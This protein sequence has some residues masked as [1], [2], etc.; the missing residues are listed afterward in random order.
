MFGD[1]RL[2]GEEKIGVCWNKNEMKRL[3][4]P[5]WMERG[6]KSGKGWEKENN[7][8][9]TTSCLYI[10]REKRAGSVQRPVQRETLLRGR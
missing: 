5:C 8:E 2:K 3:S 4:E 9:T 10:W 7:V 1:L 6:Q